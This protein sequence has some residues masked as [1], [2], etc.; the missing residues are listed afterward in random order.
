MNVIKPCELTGNVHVIPEVIGQLYKIIMDSNVI[1]EEF[2][3]LS[4]RLDSME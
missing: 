4:T 3:S 1:N 2:N